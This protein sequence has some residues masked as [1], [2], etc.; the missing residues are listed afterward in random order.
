MPPKRHNESAPVSPL[1]EREEQVLKFWQEHAIFKESEKGISKGILSRIFGRFF[2]PKP[3]VFY[4]GP[5]FATGLPHFGHILQSAVKDALPRY[6][7]MRGYAVTRRWGWDCHGL[8]LEVEMEK[9]IGSASKQDIEAYGIDR[10]ND[11]IRSVIFRYVDAW[12]EIIPRIGRWVDMEND[13]RTVSTSY[14]E[15]VWSLFHRMHTRGLVGRG[16]KPLH[17]CPRCS[18]TVSSAEAADSYEDLTD[19]AVF[20]LFP[21]KQEPE[22]SLVAWTTTPWTLFGNVALGVDPS[23][24][25]VVVEAK[26]KRYLLHS[27]AS[28]L[29]EG[30]VVVEERK[31]SDLVGKEYLPPFP[32]LYEDASLSVTESLW[33]VQQVPF[34]DPSVGTGVV[35]LAPAYGAEDMAVAQELNLPIRHHVSQNGT[36]VSELGEP[37][38]GMRPK[39]VGNPN[40]ADPHIL[41]ALRQRGRLLKDES[42]VHAYPVCWR[43]K[44]P[45][46]NDYAADS[47]F[48][49]ADQLRSRMV[50]ENKKIMWVPEHIRDGRFGRWIADAQ[51][52]SISR[53]RYWGAPLPVWKVE[54]T[55]E[56]LVIPSV[57]SMLSHMRPNNRYTFVRHG[58]AESNVRKVLN[59]SK[60]SWDTLTE[61]G[62]KQAHR[63]GVALQSD[64]PTVIFC[65][66]LTRTRETADSIASLTGASVV[67]DALLTELTVPELDGRPH[68]ELASLATSVGAHRDAQVSL[69]DGESYF[70]VYDR[71]RTFLERVDAEYQDAHIIIVTHKVV[72]LY[73]DMIAS[74]LHILECHQ[75]DCISKFGTHAVAHG[76]MHPVRYIPLHRTS[77]GE[78]DL[79]RP[80]IDNVVLQDQSGNPAYHIQEVFDCWFESGS[81]PY[82]STHFPFASDS[83]DPEKGVG[84]PADF[85]AE[86]IDM[87]RGWFYALMAVGTAAFDVSPFKRVIATGIIRAADGKKMSKSLQNYS[88]PMELVARY[89]AD[90]LRHYLLGSPAVR[91]EPLDFDDLHVE[92]ISKKV[93]TRLHNCL[94]FYRTYAH[95][96][97]TSKSKHPLDVYLLSRF[98]QARKVMTDGFERYRLDEA[99]APIDGFVDDLSTWYIRRSRDR[100]RQEQHDGALARETLRF[101]LTEFSKCL[102]PIAPFYAEYLFGELRKYHPQKISLPKS[103]HLC[104]WPRSSAMQSS[105]I[106]SMEVAR[107]VVSLVHEQRSSSGIRVRQPLGSV[108]IQERLSAPLRSIVA[109]ETNVKRIIIDPSANDEVVLDTTLTPALRS[110]GFAREFVHKVQQLRKEAGFSLTEVLQ[111]IVVQLPK[112]SQVSLEQ[113]Y[114]TIVSA[115][116]TDTISFSSVQEGSSFTLHTVPISIAFIQQDGK[117]FS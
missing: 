59:C 69:A 49:H 50:S 32:E 84:F 98:E 13:Y 45:L 68:S 21:L 22:L 5:P 81:M 34:I 76:G 80:H 18:T 58:F 15:S 3:F 20:V 104:R 35:H 105:S 92:T 60:Q 111:D 66:P 6:K 100:I 63:T 46:L 106:A 16:F 4:D 94:Q 41:S 33:R 99:V 102:A 112:E 14:T 40:T 30:G 57:A 77:E 70:S 25:Y 62:K 47:W 43:C 52:W 117:I 39:E 48:V 113:H 109:D 73:A 88:D 67:E 110:E 116:R 8:P 71:L 101:V 75:K 37:F 78:I 29:I 115:L 54:K 90:S 23:L 96:P 64:K 17:F 79:H 24:S 19:T 44:T 65:S 91:G 72:V 55:G 86:G 36:F 83:V 11:G 31:G 97:H 108:V 56:H 9:Q 107:R 93:Y 12:K 10:F 114:E 87:T 42:I 51:P 38:A 7:T 74:S 82:A 2:K 95:L 53:N 103:V 26:G 28:D 61:E 1:V 27:N 89:G 85:I